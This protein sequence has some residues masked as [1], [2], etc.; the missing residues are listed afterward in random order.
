[1]SLDNYHTMVSADKEIRIFEEDPVK[2][3]IGELMVISVNIQGYSVYEIKYEKGLPYRNHVETRRVNE[4]VENNVR[5]VL[6]NKI[7][8][9]YAEKNTNY[10]VKLI[11]WE[12]ESFKNN[13]YKP[14]DYIVNSIKKMDPIEKF[15]QN[16]L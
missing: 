2:N 15:I 6:E 3:S 4:D 10:I 11:K 16:N 9:D 7:N 8:S 5:Q 12:N 14:Q 1:M 13:Q